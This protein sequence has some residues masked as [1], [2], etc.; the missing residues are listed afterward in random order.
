MP[1]FKLRNFNVQLVWYL[2]GEGKGEHH[3]EKSRRSLRMLGNMVFLVCLRALGEGRERER[4]VLVFV[5]YFRTRVSS[6][7]IP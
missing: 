7:T 5:V 3:E 1:L 4:K 6:S 2:R